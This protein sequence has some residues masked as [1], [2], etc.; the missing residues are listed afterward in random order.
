MCVLLIFFGVVLFC[1]CMF[2]FCPHHI[3]SLEKQIKKDFECLM[4]L[5]SGII[6][7]KKAWNQIKSN[8]YL[9]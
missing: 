9:A 6:F 2:D 7:F 4:C 3:F 8:T 1:L 5:C